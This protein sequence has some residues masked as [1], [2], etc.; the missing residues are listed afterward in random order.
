MKQIFTL[1]AFAGGL[2]MANAAVD[3]F[4]FNF[5]DDDTNKGITIENLSELTPDPL[6]YNQKNFTFNSGWY[7]MAVG[8]DDGTLKTGVN[9]FV[10]LSRFSDGDVPSTRLIMPELHVSENTWLTWT[11]KSINY[12][13]RDKYSVYI[14]A[15]DDSEYTLLAEVEAEDYFFNTHA[16]SL[17]DYIGKDVQIAFVKDNTIGYMLALEKIAAGT[18]A[19]GLKVKNTGYHFFGRDDEKTLNF[20]V[21]NFGSDGSSNIIRLDVVDSENAENVIGSKSISDPLA[22][23]DPYEVA[24]DF[25]IN[26]EA[27]F[28]YALVAVYD[29]GN[30]ET[31]L[32][33]YLNVSRFRRVPLLEKLT[34]TW[35]TACPNVNFVTHYYLDRLGKDGIY[36]ETHSSSNNSDLN[37]CDDYY[38]KI[39]YCLGGDIPALTINRGKAQNSIKPFDHT[40]YETAMLEPC[41]AQVTPEIVE[42]DGKV[43]K[44]KATFISSEDIDNSDDSHRAVF[45]LSE[46]KVPLDPSWNPQKSRGVG[47][48]LYYGE[49]NFIPSPYPTDITV[50]HDVARLCSYNGAAGIPN[51]LP[52]LIV[53]DTPYEVEW[54]CEMPE[55]II[56]PD[57]VRLL[58]EFAIFTENKGTTPATVLNAAALQL[59][60]VTSNESTVS[61]IESAD[62]NIMSVYNLQGICIIKNATDDQLQTLPAG[63]YI[64]NGKKTILK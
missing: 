33:D 13:F 10:T 62:Y 45:V 60:E 32:E 5:A 40:I 4:S 41:T 59:P 28:K 21:T 51:S 47:T 39:I 64:I 8:S 44:V 11:A 23:N 20:E 31:I 61:A 36:L 3:S 57:D 18:P 54:E 7:Q 48:S 34:G 25:D 1:L 53:A 27:A 22:I 56:N 37:G 17:A 16:I 46:G 42:Y 35:C 2:T 6:Y 24:I 38:M 63:I 14:K 12:N 50:F 30:H 49:D 29:N 55:N 19:W 43:L 15:I 58:A 52:A 9:C 26:E